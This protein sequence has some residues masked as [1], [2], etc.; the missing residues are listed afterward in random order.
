MNF[1]VSVIIPVYKVEKYLA[2]SV[3]SVLNQ[4]YKNLEIILVD[5]GSPDNCG[6]ICDK[7]AEKD[8]RVKVIHKKNGGPSS[9]RNMGITE[10]SGDW[11]YFMDSDDW[12][13]LDTIEKSLGFSVNNNCDMCIFDFDLCYE[14]YRI[15]NNLLKHN[16]NVFKKL[17]DESVFLAYACAHGSMCNVITKARIIKQLKFD[18]N[19]SLYEDQTFKWQLYSKI[20]SFCYVKEAFY[21]YRYVASSLCNSADYEVEVRLKNL[22]AIYQI[23]CDI[24]NTSEFPLN[25]VKAVHSKYL[26]GFWS[27]CILIFESKMALTDKVKLY[28]SLVN[29][30]E[31]KES[32]Q[33]F[34]NLY[35]SRINNLLLK[36]KK[37]P[38][39]III[40]LFI[41]IKALKNALFSK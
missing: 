40:W 1:L 33:D 25:S 8:G 4:T 11:I 12:I 30:N 16:E 3:G 14:N 23:G 24:V 37:A 20:T 29:S 31:F 32:I 5:D 17:D 13:E 38:C 34:S 21:H 36:R 26:E 22:D 28:N 35:F 39:W 2:E 6:K 19:I 7:Y 41:K 15:R 10:A 18:E 9:A 27:R